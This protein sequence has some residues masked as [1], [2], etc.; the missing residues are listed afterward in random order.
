MQAKK[1]RR[2]RNVEAFGS[3]DGPAWGGKGGSEGEVEDLNLSRMGERTCS[4]RESLS[5]TRPV[6]RLPPLPRARF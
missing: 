1:R 2:N 4:G 6:G 5:P 3:L